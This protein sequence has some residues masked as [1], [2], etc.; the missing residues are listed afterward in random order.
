MKK[1][2]SK[3][4]NILLFILLFILFCSSVYGEEKIVVAATLYDYPPFCFYKDNP[5]KE[6]V[7]T[8]PPGFDSNKLQG[9]SWDI[10]RLCMHEMGY[11]IKLKVYPWAR[12]E[13]ITKNGEADILFPTGKN[14]EREKIYQY[15][16][17]YLN[18]ANFLVYIL[19]D[20]PI[21]WNDINPLKGLVVGLM[22]GWNY[23]DKWESYTKNFK[24]HQ[25]NTIMQGFKL[26][27]I[28]RINGFAGYEINCDY[29]LMKL[30]WKNKYKKLPSFDYTTEYPVGLKNNVHITKIIDD[31][32]KGMKQIIQNGKFDIIKKKWLGEN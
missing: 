26:L 2:Y 4:Q 25:L 29:N 21:V 19:K 5:S 18:K 30:G 8:I 9:Y 3:K 14:A 7:E 6:P 15:S 22:R 24:Q 16:K 10:F 13:A 11:T 12:A 27:D 20:S 1:N 28:K 17:K 32:D 23:G 31:F